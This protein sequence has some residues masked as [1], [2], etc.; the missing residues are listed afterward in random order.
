MFLSVSAAKALEDEIDISTT[1]CLM[2]DTVPEEVACAA[3]DG[4]MICTLL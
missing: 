2:F 3:D 1:L 4:S